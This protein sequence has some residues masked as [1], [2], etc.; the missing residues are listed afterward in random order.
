MAC[1]DGA[2]EKM[3]A[4]VLAEQ[5]ENGCGEAMREKIAAF[6]Q[7]KPVAELSY[8]LDVGSMLYLEER[9]NRIRDERQMMP[10]A[11]RF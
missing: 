3:D 10:G 9:I 6:R 8:R 5:Y 1:L 4:L 2:L 7:K 11:L